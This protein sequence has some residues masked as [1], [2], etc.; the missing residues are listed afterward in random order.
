MS[1]DTTFVHKNEQKKKTVLLNQ[2][3]GYI[4]LKYLDGL[5]VINFM[6]Q[7]NGSEQF[8]TIEI[9]SDFAFYK[10]FMKFVDKENVKLNIPCLEQDFDTWI[11]NNATTYLCH[12]SFYQHDCPHLRPFVH[13]TF[14]IESFKSM[15]ETYKTASFQC[16]CRLLSFNTYVYAGNLLLADYF[17]S[18]RS[19]GGS[20]ELNLHE[21][22]LFKGIDIDLLITG[23]KKI[24]IR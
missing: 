19:I 16:Y 12:D 6:E 3:I 22:T 23:R 2:D 11:M 8:S 7:A 18:K 24:T 4:L 5:D 21:R 15:C 17:H 13:S 10:A 1:E 20:R 14:T 9:N